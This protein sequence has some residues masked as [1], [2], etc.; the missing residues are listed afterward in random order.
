MKDRVTKI[1]GLVSQYNPLTVPPG[2]LL[3]ADD[4]FIRRENVIEDRRGH[5]TYATLG[6]NIKQYLTYNNRIIAHRGSTLSYDNGS[7]TFA[8][9]TG[10][11]SEPTDGRIRG[12]EANSNL[13]ITTSAGVKVL[14]DLTGTQGRLAGAPRSLDPSYT[15]TGSTGFL[16]NSSQCAYRSVIQRTDANGNV[17]TG[18]PSQRLWVTNGAGGARNVILTQ[19]LPSE[20]VA[21]DVV[22]FYRTEQ[23]SGTTDDTSG[24]E[25]GLV[26]QYELASADITAGFFTFTDVVTDTLRGATLYT[27]PSQEG[28]AQANDRPPVAKDIALYKS[29]YMLFANTE[30]K[31][32]LYVT[33]VGVSALYRATTGDI[34][35]GSNQLLNVA[36]TTN[37]QIGWKIVG[38]G[39]P[40]GT[41]ISNIS[42]ST[43][44]MSA[45]ATATTVGVAVTFYTSKTITVGGTAYSFGSTEISSGAG[46][47]QIQVG[48]T[49]VAAADIDSTAR[50][51]I[52]VVNR[53]ASNTTVYAYYLTG[54]DDLPGQ[55]M[56]E[57]KGLGASAFTAQT[58]DLTLSTMF[59]PAPP[60][61]PATDS[62]STSSNEAFGNRIYYSKSQQF[63]HVPLLNFLPVGPSN[64]D[65]LRVVAL[66]DSAIIIKE[67]GVYR[68][69]GE[70]PQSFTISPIDLTV[71]CKARESVAAL[72][73]QVMMLSDQGVVL[74]SETGVQVISREIEP[75][76][77][78][79]LQSTNLASNTVA[80]GYESERSYFLSTITETSDTAA[81]QTYVYNIFT[82]TW[83]RHTYAFVAGVVEPSVDKMFFAKPSDAKVYVERKDFADTDYADPE[84]SITISAISG[85]SVDFTI[86]GSTPQIGWV[87]VQ[88]STGIAIETI[89]PI[90]GGFRAVL[91]EDP[92]SSWAAG[93][94]TIYPSVG[95]DVEFHSWVS[96][97]GP[98]SLKQVRMVGFLTDDIP[99]NNSVSALVAKFSSNF[100]PEI[101][102]VTVEQPGQGW[103][104][105]WGSSPWG[106]SGDTYGYPTIVPRNKQYCNRI[107]VGVEHKNA[108]ERLVIT[109]YALEFEVA[110]AGGLG[111]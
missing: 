51:L 16:A 65:I 42:G 17:I 110:V 47:P 96:Q 38:T 12:Q 2:A 24:D 75:D 86:S 72:A 33:L 71:R 36:D 13:Y 34:S 102:E 80:L 69:T 52:R 25:M 73:N 60:V 21:G 85:T 14:T 87:I 88:G 100:D 93:A 3:R 79:L 23:V 28:I 22:Q 74:I 9:Y 89:T 67:E 108:R 39:I 40:A 41:T 15:L 76:L 10:S 103:G 106:G 68:L 63:E 27:S 98:D 4:C 56:F 77:V 81:N 64:R 70:D 94:A 43:I 105:A 26:Y 45:N 97:A 53:Y 19:Y 91:A 58:N 99:G 11:Y 35:S 18:Y 92:P 55:I 111:R 78:P 66:R 32:R 30:T 90:T 7:G 95:M 104:A 62:K 57:E 83:V 37:L 31:Q 6:S 46:S 61:S 5:K 82:R 59:F 49:G 48:T 54:P 1:L 44:T 107:R 8:N 84:V 109:G 101:E 29:R 20:A 50:S